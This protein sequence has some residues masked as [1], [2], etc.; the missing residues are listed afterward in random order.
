M[1]WK[2]PLFETDFGPAELEAVQEPV[3]RGW[4]TLGE[5]TQELERQFAERVGVRHAFA[6]SNCTVGLHLCTA[7]AGLGPGD[8]VI[9]PTLTFVATANAIKYVGATP[10]PRAT[11]VPDPAPRILP[12]TASGPHPERKRTPPIVRT[13]Y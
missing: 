13:C 6:V 1:Q 2:V 7:A 10:G 4:L 3:R 5:L 8:E 12:G 11:S 9:C